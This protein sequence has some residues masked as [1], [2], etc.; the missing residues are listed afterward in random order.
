MLTYYVLASGSSGN[1]TI[2]TNG[3]TTILIDLGLTLTLFRERLSETPI[4][5][6]NIDAILYTHSHGDHYK[7]FKSLPEEKIYATEGTLVLSNG[8]NLSFDKIYEIGEFKIQLLPTSHD[9]KESC[10]YLI[11]DQDESLVLLTDTGYISEDNLTL[12]KNATYY[13]IESNHD[14]KKLLKTDR[15]YDLIVRILGDE[16]HLS[17]EDSAMYMSEVLG[18]DSKEITLAH[19]SEEAN[20]PEL[21]L[22]AYLKVFK[23][24]RINLDQY[25]IQCAS[26]HYVVK[27]GHDAN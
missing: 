26:Q 11:S 10:G 19:L 5:E 25:K 21:A 8:N 13:I 16:G 27:G 15:P 7:P 3:K 14:V 17:N 4:L 2:V 22:A 6:E 20:T 24:K 1:A 9:A 18:P 12:M 23:Q